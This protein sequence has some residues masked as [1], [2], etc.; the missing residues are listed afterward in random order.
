MPIVSI[1]TPLFNGEKVIQDCIE[2]VLSQTFISWELI[3]VDDCST[4][5]GVEVVN[6]YQ[7]QDERIKLLQNSENLGVGL[8]RNRGIEVASGRFIA[9][10]DCDDYWY[11]DKLTAQLTF[12]Q[13]QHSAFSYTAYTPVD[14]QGQHLGYDVIAPTKLTFKALCRNNYIGCLTVMYDVK[15]LG[16]R[17]FP[18]IRRRQDWALWLEILKETDGD[19]LDQP[20]AYYRHSAGSL[21]RNKLRLLKDNYLVY[22]NQLKQP[23]LQSLISMG[24][25]LVYHFLFKR[26]TGRKTHQA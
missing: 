5:E 15:A 14:E 4:D 9:F 21:S 12:M 3:I 2:S 24:R 17:Y 18:A 16:K 26:W 6:Q 20:L 1:I 22:R 8:S 11:P 23:A 7:A 25:F 10:L 13:Q 19:G